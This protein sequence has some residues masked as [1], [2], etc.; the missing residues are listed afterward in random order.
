MPN[1][2]HKFVNLTDLKNIFYEFGTLLRYYS[3]TAH[4][5][6]ILSEL[7]CSNLADAG[8]KA[9]CPSIELSTALRWR[10]CQMSNIS[11]TLWTRNWYTRC[12]TRQ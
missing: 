3:I 11:S 8:A 2:Y 4:S 6:T 7:K 9:C 5:I 1:F 12:W 10:P